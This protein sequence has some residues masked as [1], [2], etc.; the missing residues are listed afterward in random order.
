MLTIAPNDIELDKTQDGRYWRMLRWL[1]DDVVLQLRIGHTSCD[2]PDDFIAEV[3]LVGFDDPAGRSEEGFTTLS[4]FMFCAV[5]LEDAEPDVDGFPDI[6]RDEF[7]TMVRY[8]GRVQ[9]VMECGA[10]FGTMREPIEARD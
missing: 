4:E 9:E 10:A 8:W 1:D 5:E 7:I 3:E 6:F 2:D